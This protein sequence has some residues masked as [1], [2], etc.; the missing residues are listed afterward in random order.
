MDARDL[1]DAMYEGTSGLLEVR[2]IW[3]RSTGRTPQQMFV[4]MEGVTSWQ[5]AWRFSLRHQDAACVAYGLQPRSRMRGK[6]EDVFSV[7]TL[8]VDFDDEKTAGGRDGA[9]QRL[10]D[11][12]LPF[13][14]LVD[15]GHGLHAYWLLSVPVPMR[16]VGDRK[17]CEATARRLVK[18][19]AADSTWDLARV[20]R[21]PGTINSK[22]DPVRSRLLELAPGTRYTLDQVEAAL[23][24]EKPATP[25]PRFVA[26][27]AGQRLS[28]RIENLIRHGNDG[29]YPTRSEADF[30]VVC[31][32]IRA[33]YSDGEI[34][35]VFDANPDGIGQKYH[36]R[37]GA[38]YMQRTLR[39][40][41]KRIGAA[42]S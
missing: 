35:S 9:L 5:Q 6:S 39:E 37:G 2:V 32:L 34:L 16:G 40:A 14:A 3:D 12:A 29:R 21:V 18:V 30:A 10:Y 19:L 24:A 27:P 38:R 11:F 1:W 15:S 23:P 4:P 13:S 41:R 26:V 20:L 31:S 42:A 28:W 36:E 17:R 7:V 8:A 22:R 33:G 25:N